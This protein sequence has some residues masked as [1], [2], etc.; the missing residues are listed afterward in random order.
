MIRRPPRS[1]LFPYTTLFRSRNSQH[2]DLLKSVSEGRHLSSFI[3]SQ[4]T[5][6]M[7]K[8]RSQTLAPITLRPIPVHTTG[9]RLAS[10]DFFRVLRKNV[11]LRTLV[12]R[13]P[14]GPRITSGG[15]GDPGPFELSVHPGPAL[16]DSGR[17]LGRPYPR[18][19]CCVPTRL[20]LFS[21]DLFYFNPSA[22]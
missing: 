19:L 1:T 11:P 13:D 9:A 3:H 10:D 5:H 14:L 12:L 15:E 6:S 22:N 18:F 2:G 21:G 17:R 4:R 20:H 8:T 16:R 7:T